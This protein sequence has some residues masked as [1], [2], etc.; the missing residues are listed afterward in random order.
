MTLACGTGACA[1]LVAAVLNH[2]TE[3]QVEIELDGGILTVEWAEDNHVYMT[4]PA[5]LVFKGE[6][7]E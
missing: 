7:F 3:R 6:W 2:K 1:T 5:D 4:G